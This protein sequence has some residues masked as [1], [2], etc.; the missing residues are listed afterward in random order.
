MASPSTIRSPYEVRLA[1]VQDTITSHSPLD[2]DAART[3]AVQILATINSS[4]EKVR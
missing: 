2:T 1:L 3:L 4:P